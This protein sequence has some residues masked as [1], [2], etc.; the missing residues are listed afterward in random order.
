MGAISSGGLTQ[1]DFEW[2]EF[3]ERGLSCYRFSEWRSA[4]KHVGI[5]TVVIKRTVFDK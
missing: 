2:E 5:M 3:T 1:E 4:F